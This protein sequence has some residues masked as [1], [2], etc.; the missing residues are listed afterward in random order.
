LLVVICVRFLSKNNLAATTAVVQGGA[1]AT[2]RLYLQPV[3][4]ALPPRP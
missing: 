1:A 4:Q 2:A 3:T